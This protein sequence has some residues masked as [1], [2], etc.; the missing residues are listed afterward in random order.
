[1]NYYRI[2]VTGLIGLIIFYACQRD[3]DNNAP[4]VSDIEVE[5]KIR[6]FEV[7]LFAIDTHQL[8]TQLASLE[9]AY[10][11]FSQ[12][13]FQHIL[14]SKDE[15]IAPD[16]HLVFM[17]GFLKHPGV[18]KLYD[19]CMVVYPQLDDLQKDFNRAF[20][21]FKYYFPDKTTP[22]VTTFISEYSMGAF[23]YKETSLGV[24]L[25]LFLGADYPYFQYNPGSPA[26]SDY[27][28]RTFDKQH[29]VAKALH[30]LVEDVLGDP[31]GNRLLDLMIYYGKKL[32]LLDH[33][34][35]NTPDSI[36]FE[37]TQEQIEWLNDNELE[38]WS[39]FLQEDLLYSSSLQEIRKYFDYSPSS[40]GMPPE[41]PGRTA[42]WIGWHIIQ[43]Y[44]ERFPET[45]MQELINFK[46]AQQLMEKA[47]YKP[48]RQ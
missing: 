30:P 43:K 12:I 21:F 36:K 13:Y 19:T 26:F 5:T 34:L 28:T 17:E 45:T 8:A 2:F 42:N 48:R 3:Q 44:M 1:M 37:V 15:T 46:D 27:L 16:G 18:R 47:R 7:D 35:P 4:D 6:R 33:L 39:F 29:L 41:A 23:I 38:M 10:P 22:D 24:G 20:K 14:G 9:E 31:S 11:E 32:Y 25:D 40:P